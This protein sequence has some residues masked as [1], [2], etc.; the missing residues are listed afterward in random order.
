MWQ[1]GGITKDTTQT[2][3]RSK[4]I[5]Q[6][7]HLIGCLNF[8]ALFGLLI[9]AFISNSVLWG[10]EPLEIISAK[11]FKHLIRVGS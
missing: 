8:L 9:W 3:W 1:A 10:R 6:Y 4:S 2:W 5:W 7:Q 11:F